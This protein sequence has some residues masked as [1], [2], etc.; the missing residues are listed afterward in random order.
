MIFNSIDVY[1]Y[2]KYLQPCCGE[3]REQDRT[4]GACKEKANY[5]KKEG[6]SKSLSK[7]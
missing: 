4:M 3:A 5:V 2:I 1:P 6:R 7:K